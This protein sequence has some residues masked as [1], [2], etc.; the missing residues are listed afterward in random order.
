MILES[1]SPSLRG[2][3]SRWMIEPKAGLFV[4]KVSAMVREKLWD[5]CC[6]SVKE[7]SVIQIWTD[8]SEQGFSARSFGERTRKLVDMEGIILVQDV[9][10]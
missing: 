5:K 10:G 3:L 8:Q 9:G 2:E 6:M 7:G 1:V 4:G